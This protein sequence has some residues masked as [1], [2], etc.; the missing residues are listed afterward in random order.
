MD[1]DLTVGEI[2][3]GLIW[4]E[5][6]DVSSITHYSIR[7]ECGSQL[8]VLGQVSVGTT[9]FQVRELGGEVSL[10]ALVRVVLGMSTLHVSNNCLTI[11]DEHRCL[12]KTYKLL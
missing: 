3:G 2:G 1:Y 8:V 4:D 5:P 7:A 10:S 12:F 6:A 11:D 9:S